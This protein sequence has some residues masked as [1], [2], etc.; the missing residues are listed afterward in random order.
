MHHKV[1]PPAGDAHPERTT[2]EYCV[3]DETHEDYVYTKAWIN[4]L[5][6]E[7]ANAQHFEKVVGT[8]PQA[9]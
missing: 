3:F 7:L 9:K 2:P 1:R 8:P 4:K 6:K 5:A